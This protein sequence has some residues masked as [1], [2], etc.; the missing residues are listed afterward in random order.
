MKKQIIST[1]LSFVTCL[2]AGHAQ[3]I[4]DVH[5]NELTM[6]MRDGYLNVNMELDLTDMRVKGTQVVVLTPCIVN[7]K[8]TLMLKSVGVYGRNRRIFYQ[9]NADL[10]PTGRKDEDL[11]TSEI[12]NDFIDY[13]TS[14]YFADWMEGC[15]LTVKRIDYGCCADPALVSDVELVGRFPV[16]PFLPELIYICPEHEE[17]KLREISGTA[18]IDFPVSSIE[19]YPEY[20]ENKAELA[21]IIGTIDSVKRDSDITIRSISIKGFASPESPY[22]NNTYLAK[23]RTAALKEYVKGLYDFKDDLFVTSFEPED[24]AGLEKFV[25]NSNI[26]HKAEILNI[27][28]EDIDPDIREWKLKSRWKDEY[29]YLLDNCYPSLRHSDYKIEY[30]IRSYG[31]IKEIE[32]IYLTEPK[33][34]S[35]KEFY[36]LAQ[37]YEPGSDEFNELFETAVR[38]YPSDPIANLNAAN[39]AILRRDYRRALRYLDK[40]GEMPE[41]I[42]ARGALEIYMEDNDAAKIYLEEARKLGISLADKALKEISR[43]RMIYKITTT[44][45]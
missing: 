26:P 1:V 31:D 34:L 6:E 19:I 42:Y 44:N 43:N 16:E 24:W 39:S 21:K 40:A 20:R 25:I 3:D 5:I 41:A 38:M 23:E 11:S 28:R 30:T 15:K 14:V 13:S 2:F 45:N 9:R 4:K 12:R 10:K 32:E 22:A 27:I 17:R 18:F 8:D 36:I 7:G 35:L 37:S 29:R 33:K